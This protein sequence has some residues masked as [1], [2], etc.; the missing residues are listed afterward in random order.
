MSGFARVDSIET[1]KGFRVSIWKFVERVKTGLS[2]AQAEIQRT[3]IWLRHDQLNYWKGQVRKRAELLTRAKIALQQK[4]QERT[5]LGGRYSC[6]DEKKALALAK[7][8]FEEAE[9]KFANVRRW[10]RQLEEEAFNYEGLVRGMGQAVEADIPNAVAKLDNMIEALESYVSL[11]PP[12]DEPALAETAVG[13]GD[14]PGP[15]EAERER[16]EERER[17]KEEW[18]EEEMERGRD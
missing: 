9:R 13:D 14:E 15:A 3:A 6:V 5:P 1:L 18:G 8:R 4:Q 17:E 10:I 2:E 11:A 7:R 12:G 16:G